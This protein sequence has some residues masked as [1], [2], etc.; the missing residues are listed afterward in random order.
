MQTYRRKKMIDYV[1]LQ[2]KGDYYYGHINKIK[3]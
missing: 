3:C 2:M 1:N